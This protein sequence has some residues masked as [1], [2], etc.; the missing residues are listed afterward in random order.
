MYSKQPMRPQTV[1]EVRGGSEQIIPKSR[2]TYPQDLRNETL[3]EITRRADEALRELEAVKQ[4]SKC[5]SGIINTEHHT[6]QVDLSITF[7][8]IQ[9][10]SSSWNFDTGFIPLIVL[11][12]T[13]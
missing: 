13:H 3:D 9:T 5:H 10:H 11:T 6:D 12:C 4:K 7:S 1:N 8:C 2:V